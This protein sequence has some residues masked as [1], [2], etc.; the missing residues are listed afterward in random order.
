[1]TEGDVIILHDCLLCYELDAPVYTDPPRHMGEDTPAGLCPPATIPM[2]PDNP[3]PLS[4]SGDRSDATMPF[5]LQSSPLRTTDAL[6][7]SISEIINALRK[8][9]LKCSSA[10]SGE[11]EAFL[12]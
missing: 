6:G 7:V 9:N 10:R 11:A 12:I 1:M 3:G 5:R 2:Q 4:H 8:W